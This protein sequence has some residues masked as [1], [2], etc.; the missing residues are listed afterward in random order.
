MCYFRNLTPN[1]SGVIDGGR[2]KLDIGKQWGYWFS[3]WLHVELHGELEKI[4]MPLFHRQR[5]SDITGLGYSLGFGIFKSFPGYSN[6][7][8]RQIRLKSTELRVG[9]MEITEGLWGVLGLGWTILQSFLERKKNFFSLLEWLEGQVL[10]LITYYRWLLKWLWEEYR[11]YEFIS[12]KPE[13]F[14]DGK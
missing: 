13:P 10:N 12:T 3:P 7:Q 6:L 9:E 1:F 14:I 8:P 4:L 2:A 5:L 11:A